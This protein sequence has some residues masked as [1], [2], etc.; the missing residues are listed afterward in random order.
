MVS[1]GLAL[2]VCPEVAGGGKI[3]RERC[4]IAGGD[5]HDVLTGRA[6][7]ITI[8]GRDVSSVI[9]AGAKSTLGLARR[10]RI[11]KAILKS[12]SP[13]CGR[14]LIY[15]GTFTGSLIKGDGVTAAMLSQKGL[16]IYTEKDYYEK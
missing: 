7:V 8:S 11:G 14:S 12:K 3:P 16:K 1:E 4:E 5:G 9:L 10:H 2:A 6:K 15:D 13:S